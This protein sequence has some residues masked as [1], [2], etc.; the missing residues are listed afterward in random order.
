MPPR[1]GEEGEQ[2]SAAARR[3]AFPNVEEE[4]FDVEQRKKL[5][6]RLAELA[7]VPVMR[8]TIDAVRAGSA[9]IDYRI[10]GFE[11]AH[12]ANAFADEHEAA[13]KC[14]EL[15][16]HWGALT[17]EHLGHEETAPSCH[18]LISSSTHHLEAHRAPQGPKGAAAADPAA[19]QRAHDERSDRWR[20]APLPPP[21]PAP[22]A[23][24]LTP[25]RSPPPR[26]R[27]PRRAP[28]PPPRR[29]RP[30]AAPPPPRRR[31]AAGRSRRR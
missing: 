20:D 1:D 25:P 27:A 26:P 15:G 18:G 3:H 17:I 11:S 8:V 13:I 24:R 10:V 7:G 29:R 2:R 31:P 6:G 5:R 12:A 21:P 23:R 4:A 28:A 9:V 16:E 30:A 14:G 19:D 22:A